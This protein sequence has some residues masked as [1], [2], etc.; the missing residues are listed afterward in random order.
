MTLII[1]LAVGAV[2][3]LLMSSCNFNIDMGQIEGNGNVVTKDLNRTQD[4]SKIHSSNGWDIVLKKGTSPSV[5]AEM[6]ENLYEYLDVHYEGNTLRIETTDNS[7][8]GHATSRIVYVTYASPLEAIKASSASNITADHTLT[9]DQLSLDISS[10]ATV[11]LPVE[12]RDIR[13]DAS[14]A[15]TLN[16]EGEAQTLNFDVSSAAT[17]NAKDLKAEFCDAEASS[18]GTIKVFVSKE[19]KT[20]ASSAGDIDYWGEPQQVAV[21]ESSGGNVSK[22]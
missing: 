17:I 3:A 21:S 12:I 18:A 20:K 15:A 6:D 10:A 11:K 8:I 19:L 9:G 13:A 16:L 5:T 22:Q 2:A 7:N 1:K 4:F 14:S